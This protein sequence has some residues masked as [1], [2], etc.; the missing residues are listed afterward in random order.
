M[1]ERELTLTSQTKQQILE[2]H[3]SNTRLATP[4]PAPMT[5]SG[6]DLSAEE[7]QFPVD[8]RIIAASSGA[9]EA[10]HTHY[11]PVPG[12]PE[13]REAIAG[14]LDAGYESG[15]VLVTA[16]MQEARF[17]TIQLIGKDHGG[18]AVPAVVH[19]G[20]MRAAGTRPLAITRMDVDE[21]QLATTDAIKSALAAGTK[22]IYLESPSRLTGAAYSAD[23]VSAIADTLKAH[24][25]GVIWDQGF[26]PWSDA[27]PSIAGIDGMADRTAVIGEAFPGSGLASW[28][29]GYIAALEAWFPPMQSQK[30]IMAI[31]TSTASQYAALEAATLFT[32]THAGRVSQLGKQRDAVLAAAQAA[33]VSVLD[34]DAVN[35]VAVEVTDAHMQTL[36]DAGYTV[37]DGADFGAPGLARLLVSPAAADA[38]KHLG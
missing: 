29:I 8:E 10:G 19:P 11:V 13:L 28:Y 1:N 24:D 21:R 17:L 6:H 38:L 33:G 3:Q 31:C 9:M 30:Q 20:V 15:H 32:E 12:I 25:A 36:T 18:V 37:A 34:G 16:G 5:Q 22:L 2:Q 26:A 23:E 14:F 35:V 7:T 27:A 4:S